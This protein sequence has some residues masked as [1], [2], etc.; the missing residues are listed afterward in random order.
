MKAYK[1]FTKDMKC[2]GFQFEEGKTYEVPEA[3]L[4]EKIFYA[5]EKPLDVF[6]YYD[7]ANSVFHEVELEDVAPWHF[8]DSK[9]CA[10][11]IKIGARLS[12]AD[13]VKADVE[14]TLSKIKEESASTNTGNR[15]ASTNTGNY[16]ASTNTGNYSAST[17]T[18]D[19]SA[20]TNTGDYSAST[21]T[22]DC[23]AST[24]TGDRSAS[25]N[26][27]N[28]SASTNTGNCSASDVTGLGSVAAALGIEGRAKG[29]L[30]CWIV[31]AEWAEIDHEWQRI[32]V[33]CAKVDGEI[34]KPDTW[35]SLK[36]GAFK[37]V[38]ADA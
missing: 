10:K 11:K 22:G 5:C 18:G 4:C 17:N 15:S 20:S 38:K 37:E 27:G 14:Y 23:S 2:R 12:I 26:T 35:Y 24:N 9:V 29:A 34:I 13:L 30:G 8:D 6:A 3:S 32:D 33:K 21:N 19:C 31:C 25:T 7:P 16:S 28:Y 36:N 1:G